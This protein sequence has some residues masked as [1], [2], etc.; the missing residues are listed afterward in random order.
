MKSELAA[1][2][3]QVRINQQLQQSTFVHDFADLRFVAS[4]V[5]QFNTHE[6][7]HTVLQSDVVWATLFIVDPR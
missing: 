1:L 4:I 2:L 7:S 5:D 3:H 6:G